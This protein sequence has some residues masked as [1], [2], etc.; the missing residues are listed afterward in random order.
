MASALWCMCV[1]FMHARFI[2]LNQSPLK[3][4]TPPHTCMQ[5]WCLFRECVVV[6]MG[7]TAH[8]TGHHALF[9]RSRRTERERGRYRQALKHM[10]SGDTGSTYLLQGH[11]HRPQNC[12]RLFKFF[13]ASFMSLL[14]WSIPSSMRSSCSDYQHIVIFPA[15]V[16]KHVRR[17]E[18]GGGR[19]WREGGEGGVERGGGRQ[20]RRDKKRH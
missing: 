13:S 5:C 9:P 14:I 12:P 4:T 8:T 18:R 17:E 6:A 16:R 3:Q 7:L 2:S 1:V 19:G 15:K 20:R 10:Q 11:E